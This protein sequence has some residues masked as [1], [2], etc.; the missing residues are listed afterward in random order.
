MRGRPLCYDEVFEV[1]GSTAGSL[2]DG[3]ACGIRSSGATDLE[4]AEQSPGK[5]ESHRVRTTIAGEAQNKWAGPSLTGHLKA[6]IINFHGGNKPS[7]DIDNMSKPI[8]DVLQNI[9][10]GDDRQIRQA[11]ITHLEIGPRSPIVGV[12]KII[13]TR[14]K[15]GTSL[16]TSASK[17]L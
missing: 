11:E 13:V 10:Y 16:F 5:V 6:V 7:V 8:L 15:R 9:V 3:R 2:K 4:P 17:T 14:S 12:S 1:C